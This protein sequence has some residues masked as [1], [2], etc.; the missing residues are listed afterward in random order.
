MFQKWFDVDVLYLVFLI[1]FGLFWLGDCLFG[2]L[3]PKIGRIFDKEHLTLILR[4][5]TTYLCKYLS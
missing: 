2:Y 4:A 1:N 3:V 5:G